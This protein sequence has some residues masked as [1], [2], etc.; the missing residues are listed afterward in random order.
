MRANSGLRFIN[1]AEIHLPDSY[2]MCRRFE[3]LRDKVIGEIQD[4]AVAV[5]RRQLY[6]DGLDL[7][8]N[9]VESIL[10]RYTLE[11][12]LTRWDSLETAID[13]E[14]FGNLL[15]G[16]PESFAAAFAIS[17]DD[18]SSQ[19]MTL[20]L[21]EFAERLFVMDEQGAIAPSQMFL[22]FNNAILND[23]TILG[24]LRHHS[25]VYLEMLYIGTAERAE[26]FALYLGLNG[27]TQVL[28]IS[29]FVTELL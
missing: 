26:M 3:R 29:P 2:P 5:L 20:L 27:W 1:G 11:E 25:N 22:D 8:V 14:F 13:R 7:T 23:N 4:A 9:Q 12:I 28:L 15:K 16:T 21:A 17:P 6:K 24:P 18:L 10:E 19:M